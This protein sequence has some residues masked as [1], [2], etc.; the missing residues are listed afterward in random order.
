MEIKIVNANTLSAKTAL[1][2]VMEKAGSSQSVEVLNTWLTFSLGTDLFNAWL[3][4]KGEEVVGLVTGEVV[5]ADGLTIYIEFDYVKPGISA[6]KELMEKVEDWAKKI[7]AGKL[8]Y[9][10]K[11]SPAALISKFGFELVQSVL[12][13]DL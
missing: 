12:K 10:T 8:L 3:A 9:Y 6:N 1:L 7:G 11:K 4:F 2:R 13:K 5:N